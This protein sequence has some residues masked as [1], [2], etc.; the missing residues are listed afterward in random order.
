MTF[1]ELNEGI[2]HHGSPKKGKDPKISLYDKN[3]KIVHGNSVKRTDLKH[4]RMKT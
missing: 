4:T 2:Y 3:T 1:E